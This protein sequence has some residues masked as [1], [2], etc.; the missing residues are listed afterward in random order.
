MSNPSTGVAVGF[1]TKFGVIASI[2]AALKPLVDQLVAL[3]ENTNAN[4]NKA[5]KVSLI[6]AA[7]VA[8]VTII[9]R[10][11]QAG[12]KIWRGGVA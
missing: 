2:I 7:V 10:G 1:G 4:F 9:S 8:G 12:V 11:V 5:D 6:S 3:V